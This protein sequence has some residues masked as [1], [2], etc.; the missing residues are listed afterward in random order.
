MTA[1]LEVEHVCKSYGVLKA[2]DGVSLAVERGEI[3]GILGPNGAGKT[4]LVEC[5]EGLR[6]IDGGAIRVLGLD[7]M[8]QA[9]AVRRRIGCQLQESAL[10]P[11]LK[12]WEALDLFSSL[13]PRSRDY[14]TTLRQWGL[15]EKR[16]AAFSSLS[17]GQRQRLF[18]TL[19][20][21]NS[22]E[23][24]FLDEMTTGLDPTARRLAWK[25]IAQV[26]DQGATVVLVTHFMDE[27]EYLC[28]R[29]VIMA[30]GKVIAA[31]TPQGLVNRLAPGVRLVFTGDRAVLSWL[32][33]LECVR[34]VSRRG[35]RVVIEADAGALVPVAAA[36][37]ERGILPSDLKVEQPGLE[38]VFIRL[39]N[40]HDRA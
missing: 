1:V 30:Q 39:I 10:P 31:G 22:P 17:G 18:V 21:L 6:R 40:D 34:G 2:V 11:R 24:V 7:P 32:E 13:S 16:N 29:L 38:E 14:E 25:L 26:R 28:D 19:A 4:T 15:Y 23:I 12:V 5:I 20:L 37:S 27:A 36:L 35:G 8:S 33:G 3:F 9:P